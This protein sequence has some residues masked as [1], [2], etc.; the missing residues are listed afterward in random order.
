MWIATKKFKDIGS[1]NSFSG[2][3]P[4]DYHDLKAGRKIQRK[5]PKELIKGGFVEEVKNGNHS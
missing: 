1:D 5:P 4:D 2:L 3:H